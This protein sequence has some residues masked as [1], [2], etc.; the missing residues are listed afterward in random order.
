MPINKLLCLLDAGPL[1]SLSS[2][3][4]NRK[5]ILLTLLE[6]ADIHVP[7]IVKQEL[8]GVPTHPDFPLLN[9]LIKAGRIHVLA[10]P[11]QPTLLDVYTRLGQGERAIIRVGLQRPDLL[12]AIDDYE[13]FIVAS[14]FSLRPVHTHDLLVRLVEAHG[15]DK[16]YAKAILTEWQA[17]RR[18]PDGFINHTLAKVDERR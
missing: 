15:L 3:H 2:F 10:V 14:R 5:P 11:A 1:I 18:Y 7:E 12:P 9:S 16:A 4:V 13:A 6:H 17:K 8:I